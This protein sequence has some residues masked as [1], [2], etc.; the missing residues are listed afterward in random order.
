[1]RKIMTSLNSKVFFPGQTIVHA[2]SY[3]NELC[4]IQKGK[5][6]VMDL[7][8]RFNITTLVK[9]SFFGD[10]QILFGVPSNF[11]FV[12]NYLWKNKREDDEKESSY[13]TWLLTCEKKR[14]LK[15]MSNFP[16]FE[17]F[18]RYRAELRRAHWHKIELEYE[19]SLA[20][21]LMQLDP[22]HSRPYTDYRR[23]RDEGLFDLRRRNMLKRVQSIT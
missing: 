22:L 16:E 3:F 6:I 11:E 15:I 21:H 20:E 2:G 5:V 14:F 17:L 13:A 4:F 18:L 19:Q 8:S 10:Y 7:F 9:G 23:D 1:M 12:A